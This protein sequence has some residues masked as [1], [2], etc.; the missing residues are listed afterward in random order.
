MVRPSFAAFSRAAEPTRTRQPRAGL[1]FDRFRQHAEMHQR[2]VAAE[3]RRVD[4]DQQLA[5]AGRAALGIEERRGIGRVI[6]A[7][8]ARPPAAPPST[9]APCPWRRRAAAWCRRSAAVAS[10]VGLPS[11]S[12]AQPSGIGSL[13]CLAAR[14]LPR[15]TFEIDRSTT[16]GAC[17]GSGQA[18][19]IGL[20]PNT[21]FDAAPGRDGAGRVGEQQR[22]Q[23]FFGQMLDRMAGDAAMMRMMDARRRDAVLPRRLGQRGERR[24]ER[25]IGKAVLGVDRRPPPGAARSAPAWRSRRPCRPWPARHSSAPATG[26]GPSGLPLPPRP[27]RARRS[28]QYRGRSCSG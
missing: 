15:A 4:G 25:R 1:V 12:S 7:G 17:P 10:V 22:H 20:V 18:K 28:R 16:I 14:M 2:A 11:A 21:A 19:A 8:Q 3:R 9:P 5:G 24:I 23:S 6:R 27:A 26:R 13:F